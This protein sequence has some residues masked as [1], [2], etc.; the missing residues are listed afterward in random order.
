MQMGRD[1]GV[2]LRGPGCLEGAKVGQRTHGDGSRSR[3]EGGREGGWRCL[4]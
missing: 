1:G 3:K 2:A 4:G